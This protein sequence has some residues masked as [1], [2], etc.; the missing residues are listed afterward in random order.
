MR[1]AGRHLA[2][3]FGSDSVSFFQPDIY[4]D[5]IVALRLHIGGGIVA[6]FTGPPQFWGGFRNRFRALHRT[7]GKVYIGRPDRRGIW[8]DDRNDS[9]RWD[10]FASWVFRSRACLGRGNLD[11]LLMHPHW[12][13]RRAPTLDDPILRAYI[14]FCEAEGHLSRAPVRRRP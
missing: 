4:L 5:R 13:D 11:G 8:I 2:A 7:L 1:D 9:G 12:R 3:L 6:A 10:N 14:R